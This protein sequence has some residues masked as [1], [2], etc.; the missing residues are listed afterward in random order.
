MKVNRVS[1]QQIGLQDV[2]NFKDRIKIGQGTFGE[3]YKAKET[4]EEGVE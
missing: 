1:L 2:D 3:V 4:N